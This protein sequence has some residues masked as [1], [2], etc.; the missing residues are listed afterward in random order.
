MLLNDINYSTDEIEAQAARTA[1]WAR[2]YETALAAHSTAAARKVS[3]TRSIVGHA[4]INLGRLIAAEPAP[5]R[6]QLRAG[7]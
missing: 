4:L 5:A 7:R 1:S 3:G 6:T 2:Q